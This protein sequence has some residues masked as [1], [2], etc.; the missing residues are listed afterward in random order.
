M[1]YSFSGLVKIV[2]IVECPTQDL[3]QQGFAE[4]RVPLKHTHHMLTSLPF[5]RQNEGKMSHKPM[6]EV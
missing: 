5:L 3:I 1:A 2:N 4:Y 6:Y